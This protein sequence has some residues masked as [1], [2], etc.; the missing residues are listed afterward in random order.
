MFFKREQKSSVAAQELVAAIS[1]NQPDCD[2][3]Y[4]EPDTLIVFERV[5]LGLRDAI[6]Q[7]IPEFYE[8]FHKRGGQPDFISL[9]QKLLS[10]SNH[11]SF[12]DPHI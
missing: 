3:N 2:R 4:D 5:T 7:K 9:I 1:Y 12:K 11:P 8:I 10:L 6:V